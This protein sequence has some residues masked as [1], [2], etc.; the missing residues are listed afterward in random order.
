M[1][2]RHKHCQTCLEVHQDVEAQVCVFMC[3]QAQ[4]CVPGGSGSWEYPQEPKILAVLTREFFHVI[5]LTVGKP[6]KTA[7]FI[8]WASLEILFNLQWPM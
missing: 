3:P 7:T 8:L 4:L 6:K 2:G 5:E 1:L